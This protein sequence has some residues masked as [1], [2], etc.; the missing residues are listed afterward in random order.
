VTRL[1][2]VSGK[3]VVQTLERAGFKVTHVRGSHYYLRRADGGSIVPVP[4]HGN[5]TLPTGTLNSI[6]R[7]AGITS[8]EFRGLL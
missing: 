5:R 1:P 7:L 3:K 4:V 8:E 2:R 6:L